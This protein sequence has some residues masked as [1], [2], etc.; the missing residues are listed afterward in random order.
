MERGI[1]QRVVDGE[2]VVA[3]VCSSRPARQDFG[4][5][6]DLLQDPSVHIGGLFILSIYLSLIAVVPLY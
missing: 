5:A 4:S 1:E 3:P 6:G 2:V